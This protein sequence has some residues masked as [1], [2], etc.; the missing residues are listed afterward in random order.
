MMNERLDVYPVA[1]RLSK[2]VT[3]LLLAMHI[4]AC[5]FWRLKFEINQDSLQIFL[6]SRDLSGE[7]KSIFFHKLSV[8]VLLLETSLNLTGCTRKLYDLLVFCVHCIYNCGLW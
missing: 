7:V 1:L 6:R 4:F 2:I 5:G 3:V 8:L